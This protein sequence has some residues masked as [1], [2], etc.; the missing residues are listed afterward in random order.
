[1]LEGNLNGRFDTIVL[2]DDSVEAM[3]RVPQSRGG[4]PY[5]PE[6]SVALGEEG[7]EQLKAFARAGGTLVFIDRASQLAIEKF[8]IP[9]RNAVGDLSSKEFYSPGSMLRVDFDPS[10]PLAYGMPDEGL[11]MFDDSPAFEVI[12]PSGISIA[13][14]YPEGNLLQSGWLD[15][16]SHIAGKSALLSVTYGKGRLVLIGFGPQTR[17]ETHGSYKVLFNS[18]YLDE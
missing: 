11:V 7:V 3:L 4:I 14:T 2:P 18:L 8:G 6:Y 5:P 17:A 13:A 9:V 16:E 15:G 10:N 12:S 1:M